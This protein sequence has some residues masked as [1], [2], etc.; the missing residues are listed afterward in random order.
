MEHT[1]RE[2]L[3]PTGTHVAI[4]DGIGHEIT[5]EAVDTDAKISRPVTERRAGS[6]T[7]L[8][9]ANIRS[10]ADISMR[11]RIVKCFNWG[12]KRR[13]IFYATNPFVA[14]M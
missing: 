12:Q 9:A 11:A 10:A 14:T 7:S 8:Q 1:L 2:I 4:G 5:H 6:V 13:Q 3:G